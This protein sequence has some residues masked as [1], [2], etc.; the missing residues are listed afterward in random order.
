M[1]DTLFV[2]AEIATMRAG[3][4][5]YGLVPDGAVGI[6]DGVIA[7]VGPVRDLG[8]DIGDVAREVHDV[9][10]DLITPGLI[11]CHTHLVW[12]GERSGEFE[13]RLVGKTYAEIS[14]AGGG[15]K[16]TVAAT[17]NASEE[18]LFDAA[19]TR[20]Q[21][22]LAEGV[23]TIEIKSGYGLDASTERKILRVARALEDE[24]NIRVRT[25]FLGA[26]ALPPEFKSADA[27]IDHLCNE[28][29][30]AVHRDGLVDAVDGFCETIGFS[31]RQIERVFEAAAALGLAVKLHAEQLSNQ[32][33]ARLAAKFSA[34]SADHLEFLA[35]QDANA[36]ATSG[37]VAVLL[38]G[39][40]Y[41]LRETQ[42]PP[43][44]ALRAAGVDIAVATD[45]NPGTSP[46]TSPLLAMNMACTLFALTAEEAL[47]G[48][49]RNAAKALGLDDCGV[50][51][52]GKRADLAIWDA[53][54]PAALAAS[55]GQNPLLARV[56]GGVICP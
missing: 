41:Y 38:P 20:L 4:A 15:I 36:M 43:V 52:P 51:E 26:H 8:G 16:A 50:I 19:M 31:P 23:T 2:N 35:P 6:K 44:D 54:R 29:L 46:M 40:Y 37:T 1:W 5:P 49:T 56:F 47:A 34:L 10:G 48:V 25:T 17:R 32:G 14:A 22:F 11:D 28:I 39:A 24:D 55:I 13:A 27:Y 33:G 18:D 12:A 42:L 30:P 45:C 53:R 9:A 7:F 21:D 3:G